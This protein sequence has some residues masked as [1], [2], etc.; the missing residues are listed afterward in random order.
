MNVGLHLAI[1]RPRWR[2]RLDVMQKCSR[3]FIRAST[4]FATWSSMFM[5]S[6]WHLSRW[7]RVDLA[8]IDVVRSNGW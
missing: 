2:R 4:T 6:G 5:C 7:R 1:S 3:N 8:L